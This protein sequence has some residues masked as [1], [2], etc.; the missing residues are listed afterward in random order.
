[1]AS[2]VANGNIAP[3]RFVGQDSTGKVVAV[4]S[5]ISFGIS[6]EGTRNTPYSSLDDGYV[7]IAGENVR[8]YEETEECFLEMSATCNNG[9]FLAPTTG[10]KGVATTTGNAAYGAVA[11]QACTAAGQ[12][13]KVKVRNGSYIA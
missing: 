11:L 10:G 12:L 6:Q 4:T 9:A 7:A 1:M 3:S 13:I 5:G 2:F 8:V